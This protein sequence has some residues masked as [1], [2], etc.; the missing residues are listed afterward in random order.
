MYPRISTDGHPARAGS[1]DR[2]VEISRERDGERDSHVVSSYEVKAQRNLLDGRLE[3][4]DSFLAVLQ[5]H[6]RTLIEALQR[7]DENSPVRREDLHFL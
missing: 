6:V 2:Q 5:N 3:A 7:A 1:T 4:V